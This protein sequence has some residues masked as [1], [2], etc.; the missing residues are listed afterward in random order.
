MVVKRVLYHLNTK[1]LSVGCVFHLQEASGTNVMMT[2]VTAK[3]SLG[4]PTIMELNGGWNYLSSLSL[5]GWACIPKLIQVKYEHDAISIYFHITKEGAIFFPQGLW[6]GFLEEGAGELGF[7]GSA[8]SH[9]NPKC[10]GDHCRKRED[11]LW[12]H[13]SVWKTST[14]GSGW[15]VTLKHSNRCRRKNGLEPS[16]TG[17]QLNLGVIRGQWKVLIKG[18]WDQVRGGWLQAK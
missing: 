12:R 1:P 3:W 8:T 6:E 18:C 10:R 17:L 15:W 2:N 5:S 11:C 9:N 16:C 4:T 14:F 7:D 13:R